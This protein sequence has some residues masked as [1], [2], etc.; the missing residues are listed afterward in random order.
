MGEI[1]VYSEKLGTTVKVSE[2][3]SNQE[4]EII[5]N[6]TNSTLA[7]WTHGGWNNDNGGGSSW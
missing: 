3:I 7:G 5:M 1:E 4:V 6:D 2:N